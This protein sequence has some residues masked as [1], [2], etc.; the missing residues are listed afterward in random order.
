MGRRTPELQPVA[1]TSGYLQNCGARAR[2]AGALGPGREGRARAKPFAA[3]KIQDDGACAVHGMTFHPPTPAPNC[4]SLPLPGKICCCQSSRR[5][6]GARGRDG[7][8]AGRNEQIRMANTRTRRAFVRRFQKEAMMMMMVMV[9]KLEE[10]VWTTGKRS[11][12][13]PKHHSASDGRTGA[14]AVPV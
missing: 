6:R 12:Q 9:S 10:G 11:Q 13:P 2:T 7:G 8:Q 4:P 3:P 5:T 1:S 14:A